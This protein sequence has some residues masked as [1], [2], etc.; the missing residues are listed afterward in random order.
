V[1]ALAIPSLALADDEA[2]S[3]PAEEPATDL[4]DLPDVS[5]LWDGGALPFIWGALAGR[6]VLEQSF[7]P[8]DE[9][10]WFSDEEGGAANA[11]WE[12]PGWGVSALGGVAAVG[13]IGHGDSS[14]WYH[15]KGLAE[16]LATGCFVTGALKLTFGRHRPSYVEGD[17]AGEQRS[18]PSGHSTQAFA[19]ATYSI[20]YLRGHVFG[21]RQHGRISGGEIAVYTG[22]T[23]AAGALAG[24]RVI[25]NR[26][27]LTDV[28]VGALLGIAA[29]TAFYT[30]Q[31][32][33]YRRHAA[34]E[35]TLHLTPVVTTES[36]S[37][38][39]GFSW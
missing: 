4:G 22:I 25:H 3:D 1:I 21:P 9:P 35:T 23:L 19:I 37:V 30:Y 7:S 39:L 16:S 11:S 31:E 28:T 38:Q 12:I 13:F 33:R 24:E 10:L 36:A 26:H 32:R 5:Y 20:L 14:R 8:R 29:S 18:F 6:L 34:R 15:V 27:H 17:P 2:L